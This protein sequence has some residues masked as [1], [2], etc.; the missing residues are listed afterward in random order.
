MSSAIFSPRSIYNSNS[1]EK[2]PSQE[3]G[4]ITRTE[5]EQL[6]VSEE[7]L[8]LQAKIHALRAELAQAQWQLAQNNLLLQKN[9]LREKELISEL[10]KQLA[11]AHNKRR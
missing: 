9:R 11:D 6:D 1:T 10:L 8:R 4:N 7:I 2:T 5:I 3:S